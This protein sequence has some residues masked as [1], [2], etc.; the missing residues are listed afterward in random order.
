M[1]IE[2]DQPRE[3]SAIC[4]NR[5]GTKKLKARRRALRKPQSKDPCPQISWPELSSS[6]RLQKTAVLVSQNCQPKSYL[7]F[8]EH[9]G[10]RIVSERWT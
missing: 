7:F 2:T 8:T 5:I 3:P 1:Y 10:G 6:K 9:D 4:G